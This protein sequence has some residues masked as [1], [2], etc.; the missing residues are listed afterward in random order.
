MEEYQ[1]KLKA[2]ETKM[3][4][5]P[6]KSITTLIS[7]PSPPSLL[8]A[9][10]ELEELNELLRSLGDTKGFASTRK[11]EDEDQEEDVALEDECEVVGKRKKCSSQLR[12][13]LSSFLGPAWNVLPEI[14]AF[15]H[16]P[17]IYGCVGM[18]YE[19]IVQSVSQAIHQY[20]F[21][22]LSG[23]I[24]LIVDGNEKIDLN[25]PSSQGL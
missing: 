6:K 4:R 23:T 12:K 15:R 24:T 8:I 17:R 3:Q 7:P 19:T 22:G 5:I 10:K 16:N 18:N 21:A 2:Y 14:K 20:L 9:S 13:E 25:V 11:Q 1:F